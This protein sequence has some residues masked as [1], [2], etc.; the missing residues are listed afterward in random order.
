[1][2]L[3]TLEPPDEIGQDFGASYELLQERRQARTSKCKGF[4]TLNH[5]VECFL[6]ASDFIL[7]VQEGL[8]YL[9]CIPLQVS[10]L[11]TA[12]ASALKSQAVL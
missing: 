6:S 3:G 7:L 8:P 9:L 4:L 11:A 10:Q 5:C 1:M 12:V 2:E